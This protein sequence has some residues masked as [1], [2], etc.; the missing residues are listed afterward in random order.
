MWKGEEIYDS[1]NEKRLLKIVDVGWWNDT[2]DL[3]NSL[4]KEMSF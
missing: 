3:Q 2:I 1:I 4:T